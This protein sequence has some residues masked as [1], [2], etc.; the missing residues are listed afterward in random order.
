VFDRLSVGIYF[1]AVVTAIDT[2][3]RP[4]RRFGS[5]GHPHRASLRAADRPAVA[6]PRP[7]RAEARSDVARGLEILHDLVGS[8]TP[9]TFPAALLALDSEGV[10]V[11]VWN[12]GLTSLEQLARDDVRAGFSLA[13]HVIGASGA[14]TLG[15]RQTQV[16]RGD[17]HA[18]PALRPY[19]TTGALVL[20][21]TTGRTPLCLLLISDSPAAAWLEELA[22]AVA[23]E[24][25]QRARR[26]EHMLMQRY[27]EERSDSRHAVVALNE[28]IIITNAAAARMVGVEEQSRLW[29]HA[30]RMVQGRADTVVALDVGHGSV[31]Q[32]HCE[33]VH[34]EGRTVGVLMRWRRPTRT[35]SMQITR[36]DI[37]LAGLAGSGTKWRTMKRRLAVAS[38]TSV[39]LVG[40]PG[41]GRSAVARA[42]AADERILEID[43]AQDGDSTVHG[44]R[45]RVAASRGDAIL[46]RHL[47][48]VDGAAAAELAAVIQGLPPSAKVLGT[49]DVLHSTA[50]RESLL[51]AFGAVV[52]VPPLR[53]RLEDIPELVRAITTRMVA[54]NPHLE[55]VQ[56]MT[57]AL[58]ALTRVEWPRNVSTLE[59][60]VS[61][62]LEQVR[63]RYV[64][65]RDL[66]AGI[67][68]RA[69]G[70]QLTALERI[71]AH[72]ILQ[73]IK[74][75]DGNKLAAAESL[76]IARSTLYRKMRGYGIDLSASTF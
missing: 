50:E 22:A 30:Q 1:V 37:D 60:I 17:G 67:A 62:V 52:T 76:G 14:G 5:T 51:D 59:S 8:A 49:I 32:V 31:L 18:L 73:A 11:E 42:L 12:L 45:I 40:E 25:R 23:G 44:N 3:P 53:E 34:D 16:V 70:R 21:T 4:V 66:P 36:D 29:E 46:L 43:L 57:D 71:E 63:T 39:L 58:Q 56:W 41:S 69:S 74:D 47:E 38:R 55:G 61:S 65:S 28:Q 54:E 10:C 48:L 68:A 2:F 6:P 26:N 15:T 72:A 19:V 75:A 33:P 20:D 27:L 64:T 24:L 13:E 9:L 35:P 7:R